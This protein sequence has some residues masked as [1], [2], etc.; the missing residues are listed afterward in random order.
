M[1]E[2]CQL[3]QP[4]KTGILLPTPIHESEETSFGISAPTTSTTVA[5]AVGDM[6]ALTVAER[7][8]FGRTKDVFSKNHPGGV[9]GDM[10]RDQKKESAITPLQLPSPS[11]S[12]GVG[13]SQLR[14][15]SH[16]P[17]LKGPRRRTIYLTEEPHIHPL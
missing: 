13:Q 10:V 7:L 1:P 14:F 8:H 9:I 5:M 4:F 16:Q 17:D 12:P 2:S 11:V 15:R 3:L 6:I